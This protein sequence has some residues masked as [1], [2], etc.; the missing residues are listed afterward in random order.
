MNMLWVADTYMCNIMLTNL[1]TFIKDLL[2][3]KAFL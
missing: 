3:M 2:E 1:R